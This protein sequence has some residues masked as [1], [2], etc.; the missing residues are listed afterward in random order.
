MNQLI[1]D[2]THHFL[3]AT[4]KLDEEIF[5]HSVV[6]LHEHTQESSMGFIVNQPMT[7]TMGDI[8]QQLNITITHDKAYSIPIMQGGPVAKEQLF[9]IHYHDDKDATKKQKSHLLEPK[10]LLQAFAAG[11]SL[12]GILPFLGYAGWQ[13]EQLNQEIKDNDWL[14]CKATPKILFNTPAEQKWQACLHQL[15]VQPYALTES[16]G[17]A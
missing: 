11:E 15:G 6:Y 4:P 10:A 3:V 17:H 7:V 13:H 2:I 9:I 16:T 5:A 1:E 14:V 8:L 12:D